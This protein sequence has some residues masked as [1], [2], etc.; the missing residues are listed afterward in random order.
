MR[1]RLMAVLTISRSV[2]ILTTIIFSISDW[3]GK[4]PTQQLTANR[5]AILE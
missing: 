4:I 5:L 1:I 3:V 2:L